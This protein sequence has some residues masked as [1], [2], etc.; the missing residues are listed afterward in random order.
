MNSNEMK[1]LM[2]I[3]TGRTNH[4]A[5]IENIQGAEYRQLYMTWYNMGPALTESKIS[6]EQIDAIFKAVAQ[7]AMSGKNVGA[8]GSDNGGNRTLLG[9]TAD[10][11]SKINAAWED[12]KTKIALSGP[13]SGFDVAVDNIQRDLL[14]A[15]GGDD[16]KIG[17]ALNAYKEFAHKYPKMQG[18][19][20]AG[21]VILAGISGWGLGGAAILAGIRTLDRL[22]Q[23]DRASSALWKGFKTGAMAYGASHLASQL[24]GDA[25]GGGSDTSDFPNQPSEVNQA[26]DINDF[27]PNAASSA[28]AT[29]NAASD[30]TPNS[31][32]T[33][34]DAEQ[35]AGEADPNAMSKYTIQRGDQ[36]GYI[37]QANGVSVEDIRGLNPQID[38]SKPIQPGMEINLPPGGDNSGSV[39]N[40]YNGD[41][42]GDKAASSAQSS[43]PTQATPTSSPQPTN[44]AQG[45]NW[46]NY[47]DAGQTSTAAPY[48]ANMSDE[49]LKKVLDAKE[50]GVKMRFLISPEDAQKALDWKAQNANKALAESF[51][52]DRIIRTWQLQESMK[53][54][55]QSKL[56]MTPAGV[57]RIFAAI[58]RQEMIN[59][60]IWDSIKDTAKKGWD[61]A[62]NK[63]TYDKLNLWWRK[64]FGDNVTK[65]NADTKDV[66]E[67]LLAMGVRR[68]LIDQVFNDL[69]IPTDDSVTPDSIASAGQSGQANSAQAGSSQ[70][71][72]SGA[73]QGQAGTKPA[74]SQMAM[75]LKTLWDSWREAGASTGAPAVKAQLKDM[76]MSSGGTKVAESRKTRR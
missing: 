36:I 8:D 30:T 26:Q 6:Q 72:M 23:G 35:D 15:A 11:G 21:F 68:P 60:G 24:G 29:D 74:P 3:V 66:I 43:A 67:F 44:P 13:V 39:W 47:A 10:V 70:G 52:S 69:K 62:T 64:N 7:G 63:I 19:I 32:D 45:D 61:S 2:D 1:K 9:K 33:A 40:S 28:D 46:Q 20:Y 18:A 14:K 49:Y 38:F 12:F 4:Q 55:V 56:Y 16:G 75:E 53:L 31:T 50:N 48:G 41:T 25:G 34:S 65:G 57:E 73:M 54:P 27:D 51:N 5:M 58:S 37:A 22:L 42:Y 17:K 59:E 71:G 76:W